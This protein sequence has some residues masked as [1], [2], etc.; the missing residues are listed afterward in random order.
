MW[1]QSEEG[2]WA[3]ADARTFQLLMKPNRTARRLMAA[4]RTMAGARRRVELLRSRRASAEARSAAKAARQLER[5]F[6]NDRASWGRN[7]RIRMP[8]PKRPSV[9]VKRKAQLSRRAGTR[10][11]V[12]YQKPLVDD[13]GRIALYMRIK[14]KGLKSKGWR[15]G[16][17]AD[18]ALYIL[19]EEALENG[20][21][22]LT[23]SQV[24][25]SNMGVTAD[26]IAACWRALEAV[27]EGY[28]ANAKV[29]Y[30]IIW[31]LP[32]G[33]S[34]EERRELVSDFCERTFGR[35]GLPYVAAIHEPDPRGDNRNFHA[36]ICF[37]TRP[38]ERVG[39]YHFSIAEEKVNGLTNKDGLKLIR[40]LA[41][42]HMNNSCR[43]AGLGVRFTHQSYADRGLDAERQEHVGPAAMA[44][45]ENGEDVAVIKRNEAIVKRNEAAEAC[46][47]AE[48][49]L[50]AAR[51]LNDLLRRRER[52]LMKR[53]RLKRLRSSGY[54][55]VASAIVKKLAALRERSRG[56]SGAVAARIKIRSGAIARGV[57]QVAQASSPSILCDPLK[58]APALRLAEAAAER[59]PVRKVA[60]AMRRL[61]R[62]RSS[63]AT[64]EKV[65][66]RVRALLEMRRIS[67]A[68]VATK[69]RTIILDS[70]LPLV[71]T[72]GAKLILNMKYLSADDRSL[73]LSVKREL[74][75][76]LTLERYSRDENAKRLEV[77]AQAAHQT[78]AKKEERRSGR[79]HHR[80][81]TRQA[82]QRTGKVSRPPQD[83]P[84]TNPASLIPRR[85][86]ETSL[87]ARSALNA[88]AATDAAAAIQSR[89]VAGL[90]HAVEHQRHHIAQIE[91]RHHV[92]QRLLTQFDVDPALV[93]RTDIQW[94]LDEIAGKHSDE[95]AEIRNHVTKHPGDLVHTD[96]GWT[97]IETAPE[98]ILALKALWDKDPDFAKFLEILGAR[99]APDKGLAAQ[100]EAGTNQHPAP[101]GRE[102]AASESNRIAESNADTG[103][104]ARITL[105]AWRKALR[106]GAPVAE[107]Q[108]LAGLAVKS[109]QLSLSD[110]FTGE[111][112]RLIEDARAH[113]Q[114]V[115]GQAYQIGQDGQIR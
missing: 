77:A 103:A 49:A 12:A 112:K 108:R 11:I 78:N 13:R 92:D 70:K 66:V 24:P 47:Q 9:S 32:H 95:W 48:R 72:E 107:R 21:T 54:T 51:H 104:A 102:T 82:P 106:D 91:G 115:G 46:R 93:A 41:A 110:E 17:S 61:E 60:E 80:E 40:A 38:C 55:D 52:I 56:S 36:H 6:D 86:L 27:E 79:S 18:H 59:L 87:P 3:E 7:Y 105:E 43:M 35:L 73:L 50:V 85:D 34:A 30:R 89:R 111:L 45:H 4:E 63:T 2:I 71:Q 81:P 57:V 16:L 28:R 26:E 20:E 44:A 83:A 62:L 97:I 69:A 58:S 42:S 67:E 23:L 22:D 101:H 84:P 65:L 109:S 75:Q 100:P 10:A 114:R 64:G 19:R 39:E 31:N 99:V 113:R 76:A 15:P 96:C 94:R 53:K 98:R 88:H 14:Y 90:L 33:L 5:E 29:Q 8:P 74:L 68:E 25:L 37:S 1:L